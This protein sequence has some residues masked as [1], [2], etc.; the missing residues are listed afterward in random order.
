[1]TSAS[2][3][4]WWASAMTSKYKLVLSENDVPW[5]FDREQ[6]PD[7]LVNYNGRNST[8]TMEAEMQKNLLSVITDYNFPLQDH[9]FLLESPACIDSPNSFFRKDD[10]KRWDCTKAPFNQAKR[11]EWCQDE[12]TVTACPVSCGMC[13]K[14][15]KGSLWLNSMERSCEYVKQNS[16]LC[17]SF[18]PYHFCLST[19]KKNTTTPT[20]F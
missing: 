13:N 3:K 18:A 20:I 8:R 16:F 11:E 19:C 17:D 2:K 12:N 1:M 10:P 7:E 4:M 5:F 15:S 6:D 9:P 14:D